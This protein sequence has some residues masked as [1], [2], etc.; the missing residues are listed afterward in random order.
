M[1]F[2]L[3]QEHGHEVSE[4]GTWAQRAGIDLPI[5]SENGEPITDNHF[6]IQLASWNLQLMDFSENG[7]PLTVDLRGFLVNSLIP[8]RVCKDMCNTQ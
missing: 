5:L 7:G 3:N 8:T 4:R 1:I 6:L 2:A